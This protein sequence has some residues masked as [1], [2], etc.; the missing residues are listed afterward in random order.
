M[1]LWKGKTEHA[2]DKGSGR[3]SGFWGYRADAKKA[4]KKQRRTDDKRTSRKLDSE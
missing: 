4:T 2:G 1:A 3:K